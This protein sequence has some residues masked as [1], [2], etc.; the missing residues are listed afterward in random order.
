[1]SE[2]PG[3]LY[4]IATPI[5]NLKD[6]SY[7][8]RQVLQEADLILA[9]DTR[10][11]RILLDHWQVRT[12]MRAYHEHNELSSVP[13]LLD[14]LRKGSNIAL[15]SDAG[16]P[17]ISDPGFPLVKAAHEHGITLVP[18]PG[19]AAFLTALSVSGMTTEKFIFEGFLKGKSIARRKHLQSL[20]YE[21]RTMVFYEA[22][23][24]ILQLLKEIQDIF[25]SERMVCVVREMT[26]KFESIYR[27]TCGK[28]LEIL[29]SNPEQ[30]KGE[31]VLILQ[32]CDISVAHDISK[33]VPVMKIL[34][35]HGIT[36]KQASGIAADITGVRKNELYQLA[37]QLT[38][39]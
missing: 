12:P 14:E 25:G 34:L 8:A 1:V 38:E 27:G 6:I 29:I 2:K 17:L 26:K 28:V 23:H 36:V 16:T 35:H 20:T 24:R 32:G 4:V 7:R 22:P 13:A 3:I 9:E 21:D 33:A 15:I 37:L 39:K 30:Q 11:S 18:V 10:H 31:F 19:P 5:G